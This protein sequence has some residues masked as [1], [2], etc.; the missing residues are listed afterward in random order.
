MKEWMSGGPIGAALTRVGG[1]YS[2]HPRLV[3]VILPLIFVGYVFFREMSSVY[4]AIPP[5]PAGQMQMVGLAL[6]GARFVVAEDRVEKDG[7][8]RADI[9]IT[10]ERPFE[11]EGEFIN[12]EVKREWI[13]C[14]KSV[15]ELEGAGFY[16]ARGEQVV[17]R[18]FERKPEA[19]GPLDR[20]VDY[21][22]RNRKI[23]VP[24]VTGYQAAMQQGLEI[25]AALP[26]YRELD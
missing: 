15:I 7:K 18:Y 9:F 20:E 17:T 23:E 24:P 12:F 6:D 5:F 21:L 8:L 1:W 22:C 11:A 2:K 10:F 16:N 3:A 13:D 26:R 19:V 14:S 25:R 4:F